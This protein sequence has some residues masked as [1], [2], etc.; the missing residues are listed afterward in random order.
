MKKILIF[1]IIMIIGAL[2]SGCSLEEDDGSPYPKGGRDTV[3]EFGIRRFV[4]LRGIDTD[5]NKAEW[6]LFDRELQEDIDISID[7]YIEIAPYV[8]TIGSKGYTKL[9]YEEGHFQQNIDLSKFSD[10]DKE[11]FKGLIDTKYKVIKK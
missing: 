1:I 7:N 5:T 6:G 11:I 3:A 10:E 2:S 4:V 8:Y 9:N